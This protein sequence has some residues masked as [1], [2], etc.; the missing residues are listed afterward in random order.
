LKSEGAGA[1]GR[2]AVGGEGQRYGELR[3]RSASTEVD[4]DG[5]WGI[6][7][8][9]EDKPRL[10]S[11]IAGKELNATHA[12]TNMDLFTVSLKNSCVIAA[13]PESTFLK[14]FGS[15]LPKRNTKPARDAGCVEGGYRV[16]WRNQS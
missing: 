16:G 10:G 1:G 3:G 4:F 13:K 9:R 11:A 12:A 14:R 7:C 6:G 5:D 2:A 15:L 8:G